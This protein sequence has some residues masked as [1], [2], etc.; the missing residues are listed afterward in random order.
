[1]LLTGRGSTS[2]WHTQTRTAKSATLTRLA[3]EET[4]VEV[5]P[6]DAARLGIEPE[7][8]VEVVSERG[9]MRARAFLTPNVPVGH[10]F[11]A[12]HDAQTNKLT[13]P[14]FDPYSR[15][16]AYK[17]AA[18]SLRRIPGWARSSSPA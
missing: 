13:F 7:E 4:D 10:V 14:S 12:M 11:V 18:V 1:V 9:R 8:I 3:S 17:H 2:Q 5:H 15:Q 16:P 6:H